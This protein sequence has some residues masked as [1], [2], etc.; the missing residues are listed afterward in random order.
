MEM[1]LIIDASDSA[2]TRA[3]TILSLTFEYDRLPALSGFA[4]RQSRLY[5]AKWDNLVH[6]VYRDG[7]Y[8]PETPHGPKKTDLRLQYL[9]GLWEFELPKNLLW[10]RKPE[11]V[12]SE[13]TNREWR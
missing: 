3:Y 2:E 7:V 1:L 6:M 12:S 4:S 5:H 8:M 9:A 10:D 13:S 11:S